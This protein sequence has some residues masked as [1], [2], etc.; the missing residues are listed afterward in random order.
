MCL[1]AGRGRGWERRREAREGE[2]RESVRE[3][4]SEGLARLFIFLSY[5]NKNYTYGFIGWWAWG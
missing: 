1:V 4:E 5:H 2:K 3:K